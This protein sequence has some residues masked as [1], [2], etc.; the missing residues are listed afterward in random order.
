MYAVQPNPQPPK[1]C[2]FVTSCKKTPLDSRDVIFLIAVL[3]VFF[4]IYIQFK[5]NLSFKKFYVYG[6][7]AKFVCCL[8]SMKGYKDTVIFVR[9]QIKVNVVYFVKL[10]K[11]FFVDS[12]ELPRQR[13]LSHNFWFH[14][15][16]ISTSWSSDFFS[17]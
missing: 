1:P 8:Y 10:L 15:T 9:C 6:N 13:C 17:S 7:L 14:V 16:W 4:P 3:W 11:K 2:Q 12:C 5:V